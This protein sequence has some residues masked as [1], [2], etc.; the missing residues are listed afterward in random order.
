MSII[1]SPNPMTFHH[2]SQVVAPYAKAVVHAAYP[3]DKAVADD[4]EV[5]A[6]AAALVSKHGSNLGRINDAGS[7]LKTRAQLTQFI[8]DYVTIVITHGSA[9]LQ[10]CGVLVCCVTFAGRR[11]CT[12][13]LCSLV[14]LTTTRAW[15]HLPPAVD[16]GLDD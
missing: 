10:V 2:A 6:M 13:I 3:S 14:S 8:E 9:H 5:Q 12:G 7:E 15:A 16:Y 11:D 1:D 4:Q